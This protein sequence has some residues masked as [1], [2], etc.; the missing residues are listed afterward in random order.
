MAVSASDIVQYL[1]SDA[2]STGGAIS[3]ST[4]T[5]GV[6]N[7]VWP[8]I[9]DGERLAGGA[10]YRKTFWKN[11]HA[12]DSML[13]PV[14]YC[15]VFPTNM[16]LKIGIGINS[17]SD[18][19][20]A[21]GNMT[22]WSANAKV[23]LVSDG[24]DTRIATI[25]GMDNSGTPVP[26]TETVTLTGAS[27]VLSVATYSKVW[28]VSLGATDGSRTVTIK[29]GSAGTTRGTIGISKIACWLWVTAG[30]AKASGIYLPDLAAGQSYGIW[31][32]LTWSAGA[33]AVKPNSL[34]VAIE[35]NA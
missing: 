32:E 21:Q 4:T 3:G 30:T 8:D 1:S 28:S 23:A 31:R 2:G 14:I 24:A 7:N 19:D 26:T 18:N 5:S 27:E 11:N 9:T 13:E 35:E 25:Y 17:S 34:T 33:G 6:A 22:A 15:P 29:Q 12:T 16:T 20:S 10:K